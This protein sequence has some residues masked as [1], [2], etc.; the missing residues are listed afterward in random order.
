MNVGG[1]EVEFVAEKFLQSELKLQKGKEEC[2]EHDELPPHHHARPGVSSRHGE[3][4]LFP[5]AT[6]KGCF[7]SPIAPSMTHTSPG[8]TPPQGEENVSSHCSPALHATPSECVSPD[9]FATGSAIVDNLQNSKKL[10]KKEEGTVNRSHSRRRSDGG[11]R[12]DSSRTDNERRGCETSHGEEAK[13]K[14]KKKE[15]RGTKGESEEIPSDGVPRKKS[16]D[17]KSSKRKDSA[18]SKSASPS[19]KKHN[20]RT[21][22][23]KEK[24]KEKKK[25]KE[26]PRRSPVTLPAGCAVQDGDVGVGDRPMT[27]SGDWGELVY[28]SSVSAM[29]DWDISCMPSDIAAASSRSAPI[30]ED[31]EGKSGVNKKGGERGVKIMLEDSLP[32]PFREEQ[33]RQETKRRE[34]EISNCQ[35]CSQLKNIFRPIEFEMQVTLEHELLRT[36]I[37][38]QTSLLN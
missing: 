13:Q 37:S 9:S 24:D 32:V 12:R 6:Q 29:S 16:F 15:S 27:M 11:S 5:E 31:S 20:H 7:A 30:P 21:L 18:S 23:E 22:G 14:K 4:E 35:L 38:E 19:G 2:D 1:E 28:V 8:V 17:K 36:F 25:H 26:K 10:I 34:T 3:G 33:S